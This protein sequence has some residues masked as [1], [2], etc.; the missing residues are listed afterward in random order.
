MRAFLSRLESFGHRLVSLSPGK[1]NWLFVSQLTRFL[2]VG[3]MKRRFFRVATHLRTWI[4]YGPLSRPQSGVQYIANSLCFLQWNVFPDASHAGHVQG[5]LRLRA[6]CVTSPAGCLL[7]SRY[8]RW[9]EATRRPSVIGDTRSKMVRHG[10]NR[11]HLSST[12][13]KTRTLTALRLVW[14]LGHEALG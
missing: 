8:L 4:P 2:S 13:D 6:H 14:K 12:V 11:L 7:H 9:F 10:R 5:W 3:N 1:C